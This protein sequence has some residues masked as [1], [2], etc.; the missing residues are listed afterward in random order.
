[1]RIDS[2]SS[3]YPELTPC[4]FA[5]N[6]PIQVIDLEVLEA[7]VVIAGVGGVHTAYEQADIYAFVDRI[8]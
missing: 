8:V 1:M 7:K 6:T 3:K 2:I 5:S 4:Q